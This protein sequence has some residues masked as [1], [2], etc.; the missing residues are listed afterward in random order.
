[1]GSKDSKKS[2]FIDQKLDQSFHAID[3]IQA[4]YRV[5]DSIDADICIVKDAN[6]LAIR[7]LKYKSEHLD[8]RIDVEQFIRQ[9]HSYPAAKQGAFNQALG[10]K[11]KVIID[12]TAGWGT[13][14]LIMCSQGYDVCMIER[15]PI[16]ALLLEDAM[17]RLSQTEWAKKYNV[18]IPNVV[19]ADANDV[20]DSEKIPAD[21]IYLDPMFPAKRKKSAMANK[22]MQFLQ[23]LL[24]SQFDADSCLQSALNADYHRIAVKR[25]NYADPLMSSTLSPSV[26]FS[27]KM[28]HYDVYLNH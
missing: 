15:N 9:Q 5:V 28:I 7:W 1:M 24:E 27:S 12:A 26:Q 23:W 6:G 3:K 21:C 17:L 14:S 19:I 8:I 20:L 16:M 2:V 4:E 11:S 10:K 13:D 25:P 18:S 22:K